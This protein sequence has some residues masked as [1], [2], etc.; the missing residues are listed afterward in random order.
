MA[1]PKIPEILKRVK[2]FKPIEI[3]YA[4]QKNISYSQLSM[5]LSCPKKWAL[6][7]RDGHKIAAPSINMV[8]GTA[9]HETIQKY[10]HTV[11]EESG[12]KAD[13]MDL[14]EYFEER[15]REAYSKEYINN[16][17]I[18]FSNPSEMREFFDDGIAILEFVKKRRKEYFSSRDWHLAGIELPIVISPDKRYNNVLYNGFIDLVI[19]HEPTNEFTIYDIKTSTRGWGDKEKKDE[20]KQFQILLYKTYFSE[21]FGVSPDNINVKFFI[22]KRKIWEESEFPQKRIQEFTPANGKTKIKKAKTALNE[23]IEK[24]FNVDGSFKPS[25]HPA[26]PNKFA[27]SYCPFNKRKDLCEHAI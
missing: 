7:Y 20:I 12:V 4:F 11:Y 16:K 6:Q 18:H 5:Y 25:D 24:T 19:Y 1:S 26:T 21:L 2:N 3:N 8:F 9:I 10:L 14:E 13:K 23:F 27:C 22:L 15:F 17:N